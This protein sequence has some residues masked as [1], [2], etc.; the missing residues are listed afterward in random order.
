MIIMTKPKRLPGTKDSLLHWM[1]VTSASL[2]GLP[3]VAVAAILVLAGAGAIGAL[4]LFGWPPDLALRAGTFTLFTSAVDWVL[5]RS[6][7]RAGR[8]FGPATPPLLMLFA[9]RWAVT[10]LVGLL[11][12]FGVSPHTGLLAVTVL[13]LSGAALVFDGFWIEPQRLTVTRLDLP[14]PK[15]ARGRCLRILHLG[16]LHMERPTPREEKVLREAHRLSPD[17]ILFSGD[18]LSISHH[19]DPVAHAGVVSFFDRLPRPPLG[20]FAVSGSPAV[21]LPDEAPLMYAQLP[22]VRWLRGECLSLRHQGEDFHLIGMDCTHDPEID[23]PRLAALSRQAGSYSILLYHSPDLAPHAAEHGIDLQLS[24]HTH[25]G[26]VRL[27]FYGALITGLIGSRK[28]QMGLIRLKDTWLY[29]SRGLGMEGLGAPR[30]RF[31]CPPEIALI[32]VRGTD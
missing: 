21:D 1:L 32:E 16:D 18:L 4:R 9:L 11:G 14:S 3:R 5:L 23:A 2:D 26:Q 6:L 22:H 10:L 28:L 25:G 17:I 7:P 27:P 30:V 24:G 31:L 20:I 8:S 15:L 12:L 13:Q 19:Y 29:V